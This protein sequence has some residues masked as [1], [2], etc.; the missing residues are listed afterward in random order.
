MGNRTSARVPGT[1]RLRQGNCQQC[2]ADQRE[3]AHLKRVLTFEDRHERDTDCAEQR[4]ETPQLEVRTA[5]PVG[6]TAAG[7]RAQQE[8]PE[9][10][11]LIPD[12][13][14]RERVPKVIGENTQC[15]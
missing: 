4:A 6:L 5:E 1:G 9:A 13:Q 11:L 12:G 8:E 15:K 14:S 2:P 10:Q 3:K 7:G